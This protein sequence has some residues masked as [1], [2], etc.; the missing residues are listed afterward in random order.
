MSQPTRK[1]AVVLSTETRQRL[2]TSTR[3]GQAPAKKIQHA[4]V[5]LMSDSNHPAGRYHDKEIAKILGLHVNTVAR[6]RTRFV[7]QGEGPALER[8]KRTTPPVQ[9]KLDGQAEAKLVA[10]CCS[11]PPQGR[12]RWTLRL[13]QKEMVGRKIVTGICC[14][15]IR[16]ALKK[17]SCNLGDGSGS[18]SPNVTRH[19]SSRKWSTSSTS[20]PNRSTRTNP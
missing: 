6:I 10:I 11:D 3:N 8:K 4:R 19:G 5:L 14:E 17:T 20:T 2:E 15:T 12:T 16:K 7:L 9:P 18:V 13:L 1:Y